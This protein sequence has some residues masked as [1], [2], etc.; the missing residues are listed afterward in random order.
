MRNGLFILAVA[1]FL[2]SCGPA[3]QNAAIY[4]EDKLLEDAVKSLDKDPSNGAVNDKLKTLYQDAVRNHLKNIELYET[5]TE[6]TR[7]DK[8]IAEYNALQRLYTIIHKSTNAQN[9]VKPVSYSAQTD[10]V[11]Q[12]AA[13]DHY[14]K[15]RNL[16]SENRGKQS[17]RDAF[18]AFKKASSFVSGYKDVAQQMEVAWQSS[19][20]NVVIDP[21]KIDDRYAL[22]GDW[23]NSLSQFNGQKLQNSF[24]QDLGGDFSNNSYARYYTNSQARNTRMEPDWLVDLTWVNLE[25]PKS[26]IDKNTKTLSKKIE[27]GKDSTGRPVYQ[28]VTADLTILKQNL[29]ATGNLELRIT[30]AYNRREIHS[31][32]H[33]AR[34]QWE[35]RYATYTGDSRALS[36]TDRALLNNPNNQEPR[37]D[38]IIDKLYSDV[39]SQIKNSLEHLVKTIQ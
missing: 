5:M 6:S 35:N 21:V 20:L 23:S 2:I 12:Q 34:A 31:K 14:Q 39:Y 25:I 28:T 16:M 38:E 29:K 37:T 33:M 24:V 19:V 26:N 8:I 27:T 36:D 13:E 30:D 18:T 1:S 22:R 9:L 4:S 15:G 10:V 7:W 17:Y 32:R 3:R 11:K